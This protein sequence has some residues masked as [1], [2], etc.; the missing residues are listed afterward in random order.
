[1]K[2]WRKGESFPDVERYLRLCEILE[3][4]P[5]SLYLGK[6]PDTYHLRAMI[7][8]HDRKKPEED[9]ARRRP[10]IRM[11]WVRLMMLTIVTILFACCFDKLA[12]S[13]P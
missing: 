1:M 10:P 6:V 13:L 7:V 5:T 9:N 4:D 3:V 8:T 12:S 11:K 2:K